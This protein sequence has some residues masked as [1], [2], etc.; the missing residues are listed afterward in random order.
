MDGGYFT[1]SETR[2]IQSR[3]PPAPAVA[4]GISGLSRP[5]NTPSGCGDGRDFSSQ[6]LSSQGQQHS[7]MELANG[8]EA[9]RDPRITH[10]VK[11]VLCDIIQNSLYCSCRSVSL[12]DLHYVRFNDEDAKFIPELNDHSK[13]RDSCQRVRPYLFKVRTSC[14]RT[15]MPWPFQ[16]T[17]LSTDS[18]EHLSASQVVQDCSQNESPSV[19]K[20]TNCSVLN[21]A[22]SCQDAGESKDGDQ[23]ISEEVIGLNNDGTEGLQQRQKHCHIEVPPVSLGDAH[24]SDRD[25]EEQTGSPREDEPLS[26]ALGCVGNEATTGC[27]GHACVL[28]EVA[29]YEQDI[30]IVNVIQDDL[31]LFDNVPHSGL[32]ENN[33]VSVGKGSAKPM[34]TVTGT[35]TYSR[36]AKE[37]CSN[38]SPKVCVNIC[39]WK[40]PKLHVNSSPAGRCLNQNMIYTNSIDGGCLQG[41]QRRVQMKQIS[42][43]L[44]KQQVPGPQTCTNLHAMNLT[45]VQQEKQTKYCRL[46]FSQSLTCNL[47]TCRFPHVP[48]N[49]D[50]QFCNDSIERFTQNPSCLQ[51]AGAVFRSYYQNNAPG[52]N[53]SSKTFKSLLWSLLKEGMVTEILAVLGVSSEHK[54]VPEH[55]FMLAL[56]T[57]VREK[58]LSNVIPNLMQ[59]TFKMVKAGLVLDLECFNFIKNIPDF[60]QMT[61]VNSSI[62]MSGNHMAQAGQQ[63]LFAVTSSNTQATLGS[64]F[65]DDL[66]AAS[67][68]VEIEL[69]SKLGNWKQ[70]GELF[71]SICHSHAS[72]N[73]LETIGA[74]IAMV[75][76]Y[77][78]KE[79]TSLPFVDFANA[80]CQN[81]AETS[82][83]V[84]FLGR[85]GVTLMLRYHKLQ[86]WHKGQ[87]VVEVMSLSKIEY[88]MLKGLFLNDNGESRCSLITV[89]AKLFLL[90][91][92][93]AGALSTLKENKW[94]VTSH[95]WPCSSDDLE[96]RFYMMIKL[97]E[98]ISCRDRLEVFSNLPGIKEPIA[99][100]NISK[101]TPFFMTHLDL[102]MEKRLLIVASDTV[103]FM[104]SKGLVV[105]HASLQRLLCKL[106]EQSKWLRARQ[107][108]KHSVSM[109]YYCS[110]SAIPGVMTLVVPY[111]LQ[112]VEFALLFER[113][114]AINSSVLISPSR[115]DLTCLTIVLQRT[116]SS[117]S[118]YLNASS[119]LLSAAGLLIPR[120]NVRYTKVNWLQEQVFALDIV[121]ARDWLHSNNLWTK[122][123]W[124]Q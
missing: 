95:M 110:A 11:V 64:G 70:L 120:I 96:S 84:Y 94:F 117:E 63:D 116:V 48:L 56:F 23:D 28:D 112:E 32:I 40:Q 36:L 47:K 121:S 73:K 123:L 2:W 89:A 72:C 58:C 49:G 101:Y 69:F 111:N 27:N 24:T 7:R 42:P 74:R 92:S 88:S 85:I 17:P 71:R 6:E 103:D 20:Q 4:E 34:S 75:L 97:S 65:A 41:D 35:P 77:D 76:L 43:S 21:G 108:F 1:H 98:K 66:A 22:K 87:S 12:H 104:L 14:A 91:G 106:V 115:T 5:F 59:I 25:N 15:C 38:S 51:K 8:P 3:R 39:P 68:I 19:S 109:G 90:N 62:F 29:A 37:H 30:L 124:C 54:I 52:L 81:E 44:S 99:L 100:V 31:D 57:Y 119:R 16:K 118:E 78:R 46:F 60:Q 107:V 67:T 55:A 45:M 50:E 86:Q 105:E 114:I 61:S 53:F 13:C 9:T 122:D 10:Q 93:F 102:C 33:P 80:V 18:M 82:P 83:A 26:E 79:Q 113:F